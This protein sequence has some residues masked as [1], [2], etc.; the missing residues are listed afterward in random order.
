MKRCFLC[1]Y[2]KQKNK[3]MHGA[4]VYGDVLMRA[5]YCFGK[6]FPLK[7]FL[8]LRV[9]L[10]LLYFFVTTQLMI[11]FMCNRETRPLR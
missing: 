7:L 2:A 4:K 5:G 1:T 3:Q 9:F 6:Y 11:T 10:I 8:F